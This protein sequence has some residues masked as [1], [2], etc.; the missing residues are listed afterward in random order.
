M[1][2]ARRGHGLGRPGL[3]ARAIVAKATLVLALV[4]GCGSDAEVGFQGAKT[5]P[6]TPEPTLTPRPSVTRTITPVPPTSTVTNT[7]PRRTPT[8]T[9][10]TPT[11]TPTRSGSNCCIDQG[12]GSVGCDDPVCEACVCSADS[13]CC[14]EGQNPFW[15][16]GCVDITLNECVDDCPCE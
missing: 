5:P 10:T 7:P 6:P 4:A 15:D 14:G 3:G 11:A 13:F 8:P 12:Q 9:S 1:V 16:P 2:L